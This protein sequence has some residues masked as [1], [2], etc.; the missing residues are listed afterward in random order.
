MRNCLVQGRI[1][2]VRRFFGFLQYG[3]S[4]RLAAPLICMPAPEHALHGYSQFRVNGDTAKPGGKQS[5]PRPLPLKW[6]PDG[7]E[8]KPFELRQ[9][10]VRALH[11]ACAYDGGRG[12]QGKVTVDSIVAGG[13]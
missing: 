6:N 8:Q 3:T 5:S 2:A 1:S 10:R 11:G 7:M 12:P 4:A 13:S 9:H